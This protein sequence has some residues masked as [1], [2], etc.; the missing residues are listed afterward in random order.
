[1]KKGIRGHDVSRKGLENISTRCS[2]VGIDYIQLVCER[3]IEGF[4][5]GDFSDEYALSIKKQL[6]DTKIAVLGSYINPSAPDSDMLKSDMDRFKEKIRYAT[7]LNPIVVGTETCNYIEGKNGSEEAYQQLLTN[8]NELVLEAEKQNVTIGIE[9]VHF[10]VINTPE[11]LARLIKDVDS[12]NIKAIFDP[13]NY[14]N[15]DNYKEQ[16]K[17]INTMFDLLYDK[18][19]I[20]HA[21]DFV[22]ENNMVKS[23]IPGEGMLNY[24]LIF[25]RM[26]EHNLDVPIICE[27]IDETAAVKAFENLENILKN[28]D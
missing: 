12:D 15:I 13:C 19:E 22:V 28:L 1:M 4:R 18:I 8:I 7:V 16:D 10:H 11:K 23:A 5:Y 20:I 14:I 2:E 26:R 17:M 21:K 3:S 9:G 24:A 25:K 27:E 6:G